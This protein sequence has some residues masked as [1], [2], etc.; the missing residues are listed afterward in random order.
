M[1]LFRSNQPT[2]P[3][4]AELRAAEVDLERIRQ[5]GIP[6]G[7][8]QRLRRVAEQTDPFFTSDLSSKEYALAQASGLQ[9]VSQVMGSSVVQHGWGVGQTYYYSGEITALSDPWNLARDR[10]FGRLEQEAR[11]AG[12]DAVIGIEMSHRAIGD[13][14]NVELVVFGT[15]VRDRALPRRAAG[16]GS[17]TL[18]GQDVDKLRRIGAEVCGVVGHTTVLCVQL[19]MTSNWV[20]NS[21][22]WLGGA[23]AQNMEISEISHGVAAARSRAMA[24]VHRQAAVAGANTIVVST[25]R[26]SIDH[27]EY[28]Q[29]VGMR[30]H[31]FYVTM[32]VLGTAIKLDAHPPHPAPLQAPMMSINLGS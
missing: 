27:R 16:F 6:L 28:E 26:H 29:A 18:S 30:Y 24:E 14:N 15:A 32:N 8:E 12:A 25:L 13:P 1:P 21:S 9:P 20:M 2:G 19:S 7:A 31:L 23:G 22:G 5:G 3:S 4:D 10:A 17:C 11:L